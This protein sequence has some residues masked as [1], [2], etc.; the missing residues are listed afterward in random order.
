MNVNGLRQADKRAGL[1]HWLRSL[2]S[3]IDIICLQETH[4]ISVL[5]GQSWFRS[6]GLSC[7][8][9]PGSN[10]S[11]RV[12]MLFHPHISLLRSWPDQ[13]GRRLLA[14]FRSSDIVF[15]I[16]SIYAPNRN[17]DRDCFF[18]DVV[19]SVDPTISTSLCGDFNTVFDRTAD[20]R[21]SCPLDTSRESTA[22]LV[23]L[24]SECS[25]VDVWHSLHPTDQC[26]TWTK[27]DGSI[28]S[29]IDLID[30]PSAWV[31]LV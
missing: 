8:V 25:V 5:E 22:G 21:G 15:R 19:D 6:T 31:P 26:F 14:E 10:H 12:V 1:V 27:P 16:Y 18:E 4:C 3:V 17:P 28:A 29:R 11:S 9:S 20:Q 30:C 13:S 23:S 24:F 7:A 2:P